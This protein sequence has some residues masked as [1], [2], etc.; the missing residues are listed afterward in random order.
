MN[1]TADLL[2]QELYK[3][4]GIRDC[5][6]RTYS[7]TKED[8]FNVKFDELVEYS[9][10]YKMI[11]DK[12]LLKDFS[13]KLTEELNSDDK[14]DGSKAARAKYQIEFYFGKAKYYND[15]FLQ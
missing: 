3:V 9:M 11:F 12:Q 8:L 13:K 5:L 7:Y 4:T 6:V 10:L 15:Y 14:F 2:A 1:S